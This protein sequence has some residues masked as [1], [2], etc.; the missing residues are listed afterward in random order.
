MK[1]WIFCAGGKRTSVTHITSVTQFRPLLTFFFSYILS[2]SS[3]FS[4]LYKSDNL[5][6]GSEQPGLEDGVPAHDRG[7]GTRLSLRSLSTQI[8]DPMIL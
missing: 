1:P 7:I 8:I 4:H 3:L 5:E 2:S 6:M